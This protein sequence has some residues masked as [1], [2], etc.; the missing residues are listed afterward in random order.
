LLASSQTFCPSPIFGLATQLRITAL[1]HRLLIFAFKAV[2]SSEKFVETE[3]FIGG[4]R[5]DT[6][7]KRYSKENGI[8]RLAFTKMY[9]IA[10][11]CQLS[12]KK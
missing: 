10:T 12:V 11:L 8:R 5:T 6:G 1:G 2:L 7:S 4:I 3:T 9:L